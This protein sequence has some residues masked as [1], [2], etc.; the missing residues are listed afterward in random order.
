MYN[1]H[2]IHNKINIYNKLN[3]LNNFYILKHIEDNGLFQII[4]SLHLQYKKKK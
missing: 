3:N 4:I 2:N 1:L